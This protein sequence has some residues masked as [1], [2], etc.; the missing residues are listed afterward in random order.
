MSG[1]VKFIYSE[2]ATNFS[3][4][5]HSRFVPC[6]NGH[7]CGGDFV[8]FSEYMNFTGLLL[9][10]Q[11]FSQNVTVSNSFGLVFDHRV[12]N[13]LFFSLTFVDNLTYKYI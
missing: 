5:L 3:R 2:K 6:S 10:N 12:K 8:A 7:I 4:N 9:K 13:K 1:T 11:Y